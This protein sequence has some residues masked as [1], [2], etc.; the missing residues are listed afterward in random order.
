LRPVDFLS[1]FL[2]HVSKTCTM[3]IIHFNQHFNQSDLE[4]KTN[5]PKK[6]KWQKLLILI[7]RVRNRIFSIKVMPTTIYNNIPA[8]LAWERTIWRSMVI[9][10]NNKIGTNNCSLYNFLRHIFCIFSP[11]N[12][13]ICLTY[14]IQIGWFLRF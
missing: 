12:R 14:F 13:W 1:P 7:F 9:W 6:K 10:S 2:I 11:I 5:V 4:F 8:N 3:T